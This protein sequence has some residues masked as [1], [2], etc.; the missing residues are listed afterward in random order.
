[1]AFDQGLVDWI[2]ERDGAGRH[3]DDAQDDGRRDCCIATAP[4]SRSSPTKASWF[5]SD[6]VSDA[7]WDE[8]RLQR[9]SLMR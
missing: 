7:E 4:S 2:A 1:M 8:A 3:R 9:A 5:K 6:S